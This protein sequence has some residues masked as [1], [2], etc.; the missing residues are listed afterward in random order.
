MSTA[1]AKRSTRLDLLTAQPVA[2]PALAFSLN[3]RLL[4]RGAQTFVVLARADARL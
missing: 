1:T 2:L 4:D 3:A